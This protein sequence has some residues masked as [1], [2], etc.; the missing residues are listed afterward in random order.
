M[1]NNPYTPEPILEPGKNPPMP[2]RPSPGAPNPAR[3]VD[4]E[5][6]PEDDIENDP[7][8]P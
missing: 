3:E 7:L 2:D 1:S 5:P 8:L 4:P 6:F